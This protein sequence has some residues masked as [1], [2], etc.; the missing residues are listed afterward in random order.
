M[1]AF[2]MTRWLPQAPAVLRHERPHLIKVPALGPTLRSHKAK[3]LFHH[4]KIA[5]VVQQ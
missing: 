1:P 4:H 2:G 5:I 3:L